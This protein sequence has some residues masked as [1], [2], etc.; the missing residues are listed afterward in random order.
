MFMTAI[1]AAV[2]VASAGSQ[3]P[4]P[5][6]ASTQADPPVTWNAPTMPSATAEVPVAS[7]DQSA[8]QVVSNDQPPVQVTVVDGVVRSNQRLCSETMVVDLP[9][10]PNPLPPTKMYMQGCTPMPVAVIGARRSDA[11]GFGGG[12]VGGTTT[13]N[14]NISGGGGINIGG[15]H[16]CK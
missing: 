3:D 5:V 1:A 6:Q 7:T 4:A 16:P 11:W 8:V 9:P 15:G 10:T 13:V 2:L 14:T 12:W